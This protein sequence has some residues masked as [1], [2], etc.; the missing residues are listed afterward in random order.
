VATRASPTGK[1]STMST[2]LYLLFG[3]GHLSLLLMLF[4]RNKL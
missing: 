3:D 4:I 2:N 1:Q